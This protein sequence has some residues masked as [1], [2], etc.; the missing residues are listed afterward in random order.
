MLQ[1]N[2]DKLFDQPN[3][4]P[5]SNCGA[6]DVVVW[7][8]TCVWLFVTPWT[9]AYQAPL[10]TGILQA[11]ILEWV[12]SPFSRGSSRP[13][14][15]TKSSCVGR[16]ILDCWPTREALCAQDV[17][18]FIVRASENQIWHFIDSKLFV[19]YTIILYTTKRKKCGCKPHPDL[20]LVKRKEIVCILKSV[21]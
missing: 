11:R 17:G 9:V 16:W 6:Q 19:R 1:K 15:W 18:Y 13:R 21:K 4:K 3:K 14:D 8:L 12:A 20:R 5:T 7:S 2:P 10:S